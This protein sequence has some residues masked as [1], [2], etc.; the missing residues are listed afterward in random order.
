MLGVALE[1]PCTGLLF[2]A[3]DVITDRGRRGVQ[4]FSCTRKAT[5]PR[6]GFEGTDGNE[7]R[8]VAVGD[9][10]CGLA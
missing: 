1:Q 10:K 2:Q 8:Q 3:P 7:R 4:F 5:Q 6:C 9:H